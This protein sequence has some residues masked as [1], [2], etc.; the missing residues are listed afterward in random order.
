[1]E[2]LWAAR[3]PKALDHAKSKQMSACSVSPCMIVHAILRLRLSKSG[4]HWHSAG[5]LTVWVEYCSPANPAENRS[6]NSRS[7][8]KVQWWC[9]ICCVLCDFRDFSF[10]YSCYDIE[11]SVFF[12]YLYFMMLQK[13]VY[14]ARERLLGF[15][16]VVSISR[17]LLLLYLTLVQI[18]LFSN[19]NELTSQQQ[20]W[21]IE[22]LF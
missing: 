4:S 13:Q 9:G 20:K 11:S 8:I 21:N 12:Q 6:K 3:E 14:A 16:P 2:A 15:V 18:K 22:T 17:F 1:M 7:C 5:L 10:V 19:T